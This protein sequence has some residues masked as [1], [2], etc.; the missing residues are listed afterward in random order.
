MTKLEYIDYLN[1]KITFSIYEFH[2]SILTHSHYYLINFKP[3]I[4]LKPQSSDPLNDRQVGSTK[5]KEYSNRKPHFEISKNAN[6]LY[7]LMGSR[8]KKVGLLIFTCDKFAYF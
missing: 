4:D 8:E 7:S 5:H 1:S 3:P 2:S 6:K